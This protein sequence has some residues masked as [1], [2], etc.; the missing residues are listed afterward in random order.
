MEGDNDDESQ[1]PSLPLKSDTENTRVNLQ[2]QVKSYRKKQENKFRKTKEGNTTQ[3]PKKVT[4]NQ[5]NTVRSKKTLLIGDSMIKHMDSKKLERAAGCKT[6]CHSYGGAKIKDIHDK[7]KD[8]S[9]GNTADHEYETIIAHVGTN[10][11]TTREP[12]EVAADMEDLIT[13]MKVHAKTVAISEVIKRYDNNELLINN[14]IN[15]YNNLV[16]DLCL[17][18]NIS[19]IS[20]NTIDKSLLN[21]SYLHLNRNGDKVLGKTLCDYLKS[22][23]HTTKRSNFLEIGQNQWNKAWTAYLNHVA[24]VMKK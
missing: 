13:T 23:R 6:T 12:E 7:I 14:K 22:L 3:D 24:K 19:I 18:H 21:R 9:S 2:E 10:D 11:L 15:S 4:E 20:N 8:L 16:K 5:I 17:K 1:T